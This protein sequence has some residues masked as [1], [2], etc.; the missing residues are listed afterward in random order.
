MTFAI[1]LG[2]TGAEP[3]DHE[4]LRR[5]SND[6]Q[7]P[8]FDSTRPPGLYVYSPTPAQVIEAFNKVASEILRLAL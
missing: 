2:G 5:I 4:L 1:G 3:I 7:S 8:I 6:P